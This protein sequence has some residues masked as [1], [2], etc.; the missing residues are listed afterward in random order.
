MQSLTDIRKDFP[1]LR[2]HLGLAYLDSAASSQKPQMVIDAIQHYYTDDNAN[3]HRGI[4]DL[5]MQATL[6]Y[7]GARDQLKTFIGAKESREIIFTKG[8]TDGINLVANSFVAPQL[9]A[10]DIILVSAMEHHANLVPWQQTCQQTGAHLEIIPVTEQGEILWA[11][12]AERLGPKVKMLALVHISNSLGTINPIEPMIAEARKYGIPTLIDAAQSVAHYSLDVQALDCDFLV[13]SGHKAF[14][15][16]GIG[17]LFGKAERLEK[18]P[19]YQSG[20][21]MIRRVQYQETSFAPIPQRFEAGTPHIAGVIGLGAAIQYITALERVAVL[22]QLDDLRDYA[23][24]RLKHINGLRLIGQ[25]QHKSGILSF[26]META[27][28]HDIATI[29]NEAN[30]AIR[31]GHHCTQPLL[32]GMGLAGTVRASLSIYNHQADI[33]QLID[34]LKTVKQIFG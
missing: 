11:D 22:K 17:V 33:D 14:G 12:F 2:R 19:P 24:E 16:T 8:T 30:V 3:I 5:S 6:A 10:G 15:P 28:P 32:E 4:Y 27:H 34:G 26:V 18:M 31:A 20:G 25:A 23:T 29:L 7:E 1:L 21:G 9:K 13:F